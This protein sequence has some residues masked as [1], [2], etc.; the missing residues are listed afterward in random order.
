[1]KEFETVVIG[2]GPGGIA[3]AIRSA[4]LGGKVCLVEAGAEHLGGTCTNEGCIPVKSFLESAELYARIRS[5][6]GFGLKASVESPDLSRIASAA[7]GASAKLRAGVAFRLKQKGVEVLYGR[8]R[9]TSELRLETALPNG[10]SETVEASKFVIATGSVPKPLP[11]LTVDEKCLLSSRGILDL[12]ELPANLLIVG[13]GYIGCEFASIF[14]LLGSEV[15][16]V[17]IAGRILPTED[18][19]VSRTL[20]REFKKR[21]IRIV[22][23]SVVKSF[24]LQD[25]VVN[26]EIAPADG[27]DGGEVRDYS[28]VLVA[29]GRQ[30]A[31][32]GLGLE[33]AGVL[34]EKGF[35]SVDKK[36]ITTQANIAACGDA[37]A[38]PMLAHT[39]SREGLVAAESLA[40]VKHV[41]TAR[42]VPRIVFSEPQIGSVGLTESQAAA[43]SPDIVI[44]RGFFKANGRAVVMQNDGGFVKLIAAKDSGKLLGA[45]IVGPYAT[46]I[47][48]ELGLAMENGLTLEAVA[49]TL[50]GHPTLAELIGD[51]ALEG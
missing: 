40:E 3:A 50:H 42:F 7:R 16:V 29:S 49:R 38:T 45:S 8:A 46:E 26:C 17:D 10:S 24:S 4:E 33:Q 18:E 2:G 14:S 15:T 36:L 6:E 43:E 47:V 1:M 31:L 23:G 51:V 11:G 21:G 27:M 32:D 30:A 22:T 35:V 25:G 13:G 20:A 9:F 37:I 39:A 5:A 12:P 48:H 19:E 41:H 34:I 28:R 44:R